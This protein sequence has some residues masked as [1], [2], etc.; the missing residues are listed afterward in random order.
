[1][2][3]PNEEIKY[4]LQHLASCNP[5]DIDNSE[6]DVEYE[7]D[8]VEGFAQVCCVD[9]AK[10]ALNRIEEL[11]ALTE[12]LKFE[13]QSIESKKDNLIETLTQLKDS[14]GDGW[15]SGF[16][17]AKKLHKEGECLFGYSDSDVLRLSENAGSLSD[18]ECESTFNKIHKVMYT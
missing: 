4:Q 2:I 11:E 18:E 15:Y 8:G 10:R 3:T 5:S 13:A 12:K 1:M 7:V 14:F 17:E 6:F 16:L 9:V